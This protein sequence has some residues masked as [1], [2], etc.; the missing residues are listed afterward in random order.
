MKSIC[1]RVHSCGYAKIHSGCIPPCLP[2][3]K[4][5][6]CVLMD[7]PTDHPRHQ[8]LCQRHALVE[9]V[10][11]GITTQSG[12]IAHGRGEAFDYL[13]LEKTHPFALEAIHEAAR[14]L[15]SARHAVL[16]VNGN[17]AALAMDDVASL[18]A[19]TGA[20]IEI[21]LFYWSQEREDAIIGAFADAHPGLK[22]LTQE[23]GIR[24][25]GISSQRGKVHH[26]G[27]LDADVVLTP[28]E[29]G[30]RAQALVACGKKVITI[31]LNPFSR[32]AQSATVSIVDN[33]VRAMPLITQAA[34]QYTAHGTLPYVHEPYDNTRVLGESV[35]F[36][37][38]R[39]YPVEE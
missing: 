23:E 31:D 11:R 29:D 35:Q 16:S 17:V 37:R 28:L 32:T 8:S 24:I 22:V 14:L 20:D 26:E 30:D 21:N 3:A 27:I 1:S 25:P 5:G 38:S 4:K 39:P 2:V 19:A 36:L 12:L 9:G 15:C 13:F 10:K 34:Q 6:A 7:I 33:V 18:S